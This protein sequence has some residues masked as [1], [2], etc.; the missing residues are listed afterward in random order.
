MRCFVH[1]DFQMCFAPQRRAMACNF[2]SLI[3]PDG[4]APAVLASLLFD[5]PEPQI[6]GKREFSTFSCACI[7]LLTL[8]LLWS[9]LFCSSLLWLFPPLLFHL[10]ILSEVWLLNFLRIKEKGFKIKSCGERLHFIWGRGQAQNAWKLKHTA[11]SILA[12]GVGVQS[13]QSMIL[14]RF[15]GIHPGSSHSD[16]NSCPSMS[17][18]PPL[19]RQAC[20]PYKG[21]ILSKACRPF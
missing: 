13:P 20:K 12:S 11:I 10:S 2:S 16:N 9:S 1:C 3:W 6:I 5:P 4:S 7:F 19:P 21:K 14:C 15:V 17:L 8:S 18:D